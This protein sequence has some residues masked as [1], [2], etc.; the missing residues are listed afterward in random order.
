MELIFFTVSV[1]TFTIKS[2]V[3]LIITIQNTPATIKN[4]R[5]LNNRYCP[6]RSIPHKYNRKKQQYN[7]TGIK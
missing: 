7:K 4:F 1:V 3:G 6:L 5:T 2:M